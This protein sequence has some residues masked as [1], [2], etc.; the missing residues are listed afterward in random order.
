[1]GESIAQHS[2]KVEIM[3]RVRAV[4]VKCEPYEYFGREIAQRTT[5]V[6]KQAD[7]VCVQRG[8]SPVSKENF[9]RRFDNGREHNRARPIIGSIYLRLKLRE[10]AE[11]GSPAENFLKSRMY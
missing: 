10:I 7:V 5:E 3:T 9:K 4:Q 8:A 2:N 11:P 6:K 1:M